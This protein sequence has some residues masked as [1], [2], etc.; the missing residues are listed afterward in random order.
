MGVGAGV[1][2][3]I[4]LG[5][6]NA[7]AEPIDGQNLTVGQT[8]DNY[9]WIDDSIDIATSVN[10]TMSFDEAFA[11]ARAEVGPGGAFEW[12]GGIYG[13]FYAEEWANMSDEE[14]AEY[15]AMFHWDDRPQYNNEPLKPELAD[16]ESSDETTAQVL[17]NGEVLIEDNE[18]IDSTTEDL[19]AETID[20]ETENVITADTDPEFEVLGVEQGDLQAMV[21]DEEIHLIDIDNDGDIN[22]T[23]ETADIDDMDLLANNTLPGDD[24]FIDYISDNELA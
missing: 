24:D 17:E 2:G 18:L 1:V 14:K 9:E 12:R 15:N 8:E 10:D 5:T 6:L 11:A 16:P 21:D 3:G 13:T 19:V 23:A 7:S 22:Y 4:L 20:D